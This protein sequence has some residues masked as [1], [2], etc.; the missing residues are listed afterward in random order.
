M[1]ATTHRNTRHRT[2]DI[3]NVPVKG[4]TTILGGTIVVIG[5]DNFAVMGTA[6]TGLAAIGV[7]K[8]TVVNAGADG[9]A[10]A[11]VFTG[12]WGPFANSASSDAISLDDIGKTCF[13]VNNQTVALTNGSSSRSAAGTVFMVDAE[14]VWVRFN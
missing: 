4:A 2:G 1:T 13:I 7:C 11:E 9:A 10:R 8:D 12:I 3:R 14:G 6:A 5:S